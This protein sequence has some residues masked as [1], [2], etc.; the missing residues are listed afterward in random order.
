MN[1]NLKIEYD[2][3]LREYMDLLDYCGKHSDSFTLI[4]QLKSPYSKIPPNLKH[5]ELLKPIEP[6]LIEQVLGLRQWPGT[7]M[8]AIHNVL[9]RYKSCKETRKF[10]A[11]AP[12][13]L[14]SQGY[15]GLPEDICFYR[16]GKPWL[17]STS[18]EREMSMIEF[19]KDD[20]DFLDN[21]NI[22]YTEF[23][24]DTSWKILGI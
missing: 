2:D 15:L 17:I 24:S 14:V 10:L 16:S 9:N 20:C 22:K 7:M 13:M 23:H 12:N 8:V 11:G 4:T 19:T 18:H 6:F 5:D 1:H 3:A 21:H